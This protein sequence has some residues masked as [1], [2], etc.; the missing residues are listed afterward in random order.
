MKHKLE[1]RNK[2]KFLPVILFLISLFLC[3]SSPVFASEKVKLP[4]VKID[5]SPEAIKRGEEVFKSICNGC[6]GLKYYGLKAQLD[7]E[8]ARAAFGKEPPDLSLLAK[9]RGKRDE[10]AK[11]IY[12]LLI[13]YND[14]PEKN[15]VFPNIAMPPVFSKDDPEFAQKAKDVAAFLL[16][17][18]EPTAYE[19]RHLGKYLL[20]YMIA[21]TT[22]LYALNRKTWRGV[23][24][25]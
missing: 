20:A 2:R 16:Y 13:S 9:A 19:R 12:A 21:L 24:K 8:A 23:K 10:G 15:P 5:F 25:R 14:T 18:A 7:A 17:V 4:Q 3:L 6:H 22:L 1:I 11:Y